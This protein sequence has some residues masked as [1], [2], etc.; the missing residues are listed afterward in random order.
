MT[1]STGKILYT[2]RLATHTH[3]SHLH[4]VVTHAGEASIFTHRHCCITGMNAV[5]QK[6]HGP[7]VDHAVSKWCS[8]PQLGLV[9]VVRVWS[10]SNR[11]HAESR[12]CSEDP[13]PDLHTWLPWEVRLE[14]IQEAAFSRPTSSCT[15]PLANCIRAECMAC[16]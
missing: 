12:E 2:N 9:L 10:V 11:G 5:H 7:M 3:T 16:E 13:S 4:R 8:V 14:E 6:T 1:L 15:M